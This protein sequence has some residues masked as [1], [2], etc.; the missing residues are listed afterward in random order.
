MSRELVSWHPLQ[1]VDRFFDDN[2]MG[3]MHTGSVPML[4]VYQDGDNVMVD[5]QLPGIDPK[6]IEID[7]ENDVLTIAGSSGDTKEIKKE[8]Y[9]RKEI[10]SGSFRRN[11][12]LPMPV[13]GDKAEASYEK[14][15]LTITLP[16][17]EAAKPKK[18]SVKVK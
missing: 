1:E 15:I 10:R 9:Y 7:V 14:G 6:D 11:I 13:K 12:I 2:L 5:V 3:M 4:N 18:I 17:H 8:N 16:K